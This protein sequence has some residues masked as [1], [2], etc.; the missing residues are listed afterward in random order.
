MAD[1]AALEAGRVRRA[2]TKLGIV[3]A[4]S[5]GTSVAYAALIRNS[6]DHVA[7]F[8]RQSAKVEAEVLDLAHG[9]QFT[10]APQVSGGAEIDHLAESDVVVIT[11]GAKQQ[12]GQSRLELAEA[13]ARMMRGLMPSLVAC[14]PDAIFLVVTNPA[15]V[16]TVVAQRCAALPPNRVFSTGTVLDSSRLRW[17]LAREA[18]VAVASVHAMIIGEHGDS[19]F[20][21]WSSARIGPVP[22]REW[23]PPGRGRFR[24]AE[25]DGIA[26]AVRG[27]AARVIAGKG[28]TNYA[29]GLAA[30]R[31]VEA[32][33]KDERAV[34]PVSSI[35]SDYRGLSGIALSVPT[36]VGAEGVVRVV[37]TPMDDQEIAL[38]HRSAEALRNT[39]RSMK[40]A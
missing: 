24:P 26:A 27:A 3:G 20:P 37:D 12:P 30:A 4:G 17:M 22:A 34:L 7:L 11:A 5:V 23:A 32:V 19:Q 13:N 18:G 40:S 21:L 38:L 39:V 9:T 36:V 1:A 15:D 29:I 25:L 33:L 28:A 2:P 14:A 16:L 8:D 35:L 31:V 6:A 10:G